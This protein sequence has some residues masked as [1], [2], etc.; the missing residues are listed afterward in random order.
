MIKV[1]RGTTEF[2]DVQFEILSGGSW[3]GLRNRVKRERIPTASHPYTPTSLLTELFRPPP[4][5][6][7]PQNPISSFDFL[8]NKISQFIRFQNTVVYGFGK[9]S[10]S[11][12]Y[13]TY[14]HVFT[15]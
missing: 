1:N 4:P 2:R 12:M 3:L 9:E 6:Q 14:S 8:R 11:K 10:T 7:P 5:Q 13:R 15:A